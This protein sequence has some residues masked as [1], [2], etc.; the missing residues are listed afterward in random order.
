MWIL[1]AILYILGLLILFMVLALCII[2]IGFIVLYI[3]V[4]VEK[5]KEKEGIFHKVK[6]TLDNWYW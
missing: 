1:C 4:F 2:G 3:G 6:D 5:I